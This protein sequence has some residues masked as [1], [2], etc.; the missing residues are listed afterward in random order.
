MDIFIADVLLNYV[1]QPKTNN[2][3]YFCNVFI[4]LSNLVWKDLNGH[5]ISM[6][7]HQAHYS[8]YIYK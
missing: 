7:S 4:Q 2:K 3:S 1:A 5:E 6:L 8:I